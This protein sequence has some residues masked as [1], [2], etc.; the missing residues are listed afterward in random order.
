MLQIT[1]IAPFYYHEATPSSS[2][3]TSTPSSITASTS[4]S[5]QL[6]V[7]LSTVTK[8]MVTGVKVG[9]HTTVKD[10]CDKVWDKINGKNNH[11]MRV[12]EVADNYETPYLL[13]KNMRQFG[14]AH[15]I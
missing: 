6:I 14:V 12:D 2:T 15:E 4:T 5:T 13:N 3:T 9:P 8:V 11:Y 1:Y 10:F 7:D